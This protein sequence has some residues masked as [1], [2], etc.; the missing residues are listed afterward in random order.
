MGGVEGK[1]CGVHG[2]LSGFCV[3]PGELLINGSPLS[4]VG[5]ANGGV[6][7]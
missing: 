2:G 1:A 4:F 3:A 6:G 5:V 7:E